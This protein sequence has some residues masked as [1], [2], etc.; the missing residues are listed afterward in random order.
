MKAARFIVLAGLL[1]L[2]VSLTSA[3]VRLPRLI[4]SNMVLQ[5]ESQVRIWGWA[6]PAEEVTV[7]TNW[8]SFTIKPVKADQNGKWQRF[9][10]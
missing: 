9:S 6:D 8:Q 2:F 3:D 5:R 1:V 10:F 7:S 4:G